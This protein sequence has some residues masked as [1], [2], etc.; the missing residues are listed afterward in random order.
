MLI[1]ENKKCL[2]NRQAKIQCFESVEHPGETGC[3]NGNMAPLLEPSNSEAEVAS[4]PS[5]NMMNSNLEE[6]AQDDHPMA[7]A[8]AEEDNAE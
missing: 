4:L 5:Q 2:C 7:E 3:G 8:E 1:Y 6:L